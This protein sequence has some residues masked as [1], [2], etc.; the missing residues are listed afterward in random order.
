MEGD[1][2]I[3]RAETLILLYSQGYKEIAYMDENNNRFGPFEPLDDKEY[4]SIINKS[5]KDLFKDKLRKIPKSIYAYNDFRNFS[6]IVKM[7][8]RKMYY[9]DS[10][11]Q[12]TSVETY[13]PS[14]YFKIEDDNIYVFVHNKNVLYDNPLPNTIGNS[15]FCYG[16]IQLKHKSCET[17]QEKID[18]IIHEYYDTYFS[19]RYNDLDNW[20]E[21][22]FNFKKMNKNVLETKS[23]IDIQ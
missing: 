22:D 16:N 3:Q 15:T 2:L 13:W 5:N 8:W 11:G 9:L 1:E 4:K 17:I 23:F 20:I 7:C 18:A 19:Y 12:K 10:K 14:L 21:G 6:F